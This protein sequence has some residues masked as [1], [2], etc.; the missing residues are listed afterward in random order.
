MGTA[1]RDLTADDPRHGTRNG[2]V[3]L[4]CRCDR[5]R[6]ANRRSM[7]EKRRRMAEGATGEHGRAATYTNHRC[8]CD[9][10]R[11]ANAADQ[12]RRRGATTGLPADDPRHGLATT[13]S[14]HRCRCDRCRAAWAAYFAE[15]RGR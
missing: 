13:Y 3:N 10:C 5:C 8:R 7:A 11:D 9:A 12:R 1:R 15:R 4:G 14:N 2:Y 6:E